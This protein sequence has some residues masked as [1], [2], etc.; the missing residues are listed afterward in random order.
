M[1]WTTKMIRSRYSNAVDKNGR[2]RRDGMTYTYKEIKKPEISDDTLNRKRIIAEMET[3]CNNGENLDEI[4]KEIECRPE[5][6]EQFAYFYKNGFSNLS[7]IFKNWY[8]SK[9][10]N[11]QKNKDINNTR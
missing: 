4:V 5:I 3:R 7:D 10:R 1:G 2:L 11:K 6:K 9:Q 8:I